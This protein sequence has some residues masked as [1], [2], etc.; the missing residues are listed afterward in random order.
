M[1]ALDNLCHNPASLSNLS[2]N[3]VT[4]SGS[5]LGDNDRRAGT[6]PAPTEKITLGHIVG[7]FKSITTHGYIT[8]V[9]HQ[10]WEPFHQRLWQRNYYEHIIRDNEA[11]QTLRHYIVLN[12]KTWKN[13]QLYPIVEISW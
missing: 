6:R 3:N 9:H 5:I 12:P 2:C 1:G 10:D 13:D 11:L 7:A 8:G 4:H